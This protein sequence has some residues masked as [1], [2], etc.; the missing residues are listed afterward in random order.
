MSL[1]RIVAARVLLAVAALLGTGVAQTLT[2]ATLRRLTLNQ[3]PQSTGLSAGGTTRIGGGAG[4]GGTGDSLLSVF[5]QLYGRSTAERLSGIRRVHF[6]KDGRLYQNL[7]ERVTVVP[8]TA[9]AEMQFQLE[10]L[11]VNM[12]RPDPVALAVARSRYAGHSG[13]LF[14]DR[15]FRIHDPRLAQLNYTVSSQTRLVAGRQVMVHTITPRVPDRSSFEVHVDLQLDFVVRTKEFNAF[16]ALVFDMDWESYQL[17]PSASL[18]PTFQAWQPIHQVQSFP[19][20]AAATQVVR[21][22]FV[23]RIPRATALP[24]GYVLSQVRITTVDEGGGVRRRYLVLEYTDG[25]DCLFLVESAAPGRSDETTVSFEGVHQCVQGA[26]CQSWAWSN[27][28]Q[29]LVVSRTLG[30]QVPNLIKQALRS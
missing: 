13:F 8:A 1:P 11:D 18:P 20:V 27:G 24:T 10:L 3:A 7:R 19:D 16:G 23:P 17:G 2:G 5:D 28:V 29:F 30:G 9:T 4:G 15:D 22:E 12:P 26:H 14:F 21:K 6:Y 25:I